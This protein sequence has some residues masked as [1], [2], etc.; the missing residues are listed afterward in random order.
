MTQVHNKRGFTLVEL[1]LAMSF[2]SVLLLAIAMTAIQVGKIYNKGLVLD[3][4]NQAGRDTGDSLRRDFLQTDAQKVS[5]A[6]PG[7]T[8]SVISFKAVDGSVQ[9]GRLCLGSVSYLWNSPESISSPSVSGQTVVDGA[10]RPINFIRIV[11]EGGA[12]CRPS[13]SGVY[14]FKIGNDVP[15]TDLLKQPTDGSDIVMVVY[16]MSVSPIGEDAL[17]AER[18]YKINYKIGT[19]E[20]SEI[21]SSDQSCRPPSSDASNEEFCAINYFETIVRT[22]GGA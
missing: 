20:K 9:S 21:N 8:E 10:N 15:R 13:S 7:G 1:M 4:L 22:N 3:V 11:D 19:S 6:N 12:L 17:G 14:Q 5:R 2:V 18:L 16:S